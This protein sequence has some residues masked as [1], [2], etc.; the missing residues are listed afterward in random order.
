MSRGTQPA[1]LISLLSVLVVRDTRAGAVSSLHTQRSDASGVRAFSDAI[2]HGEATIMRQHPEDFQLLR[3]GY[4]DDESGELQTC[5]PV[6]LITA[7]DVVRRAE[8]E[9]P[10]MNKS[11]NNVSDAVNDAMN[12]VVRNQ[13]SLEGV[14]G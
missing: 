11:M 3:I 12:D 2:L 9:R 14:N 7:A 8:R 13:L 1:A 5:E 6:V 4:L 10:S